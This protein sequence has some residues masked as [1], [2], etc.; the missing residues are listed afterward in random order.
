MTGYVLSFNRKHRRRGHLFD[1][2]YRS[3]VCEKEP[4]LLELV[5]YIH[6]RPLEAGVVKSL[7]ELDKYPWAGHYALMNHSS[8]SPSLDSAC[9]SSAVS[10]DSS[11]AAFADS[12]SAAFA[13]SSSAVSAD[14][15][16]AAFAFPSSAVFADLSA[17]FAGSYR[18]F[19]E[20]GRRKEGLE[21]ILRQARDGGRPADVRVLGSE[22]F[23]KRVLREAG[24]VKEAKTR[25]ISLE[26]LCQKI[27]SRFRVEEREMRSPLKKRSAADAKA[28]F[29]YLAIREMGYSGRE[30]GD[31]LNMSGYSAIRRS[32]KGRGV[33]HGNGLSVTEFL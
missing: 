31:Y 18:D 21:H 32:E 11:S 23:V 22:E 2:R 30:V 7:S 24:E 3:T 4:Y 15:S 17:A 28:A 27:L 10:A 16:S 14:S 26:D 5:R 33:L 19:V 12:S 8:F 20:R 13:D 25:S 6:L 9:P 1:S 29:T